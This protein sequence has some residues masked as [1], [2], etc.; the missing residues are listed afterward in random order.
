MRRRAQPA[1][2]KPPP[3]EPV[4]QLSPPQGSGGGDNYDDGDEGEMPDEYERRKPM[5]QRQEEPEA[6]P[7]DEGSA[8]TSQIWLARWWHPLFVLPSPW[9]GSSGLRPAGPK[10]GSAQSSQFSR[11]WLK[12]TAGWVHIHSHA[13]V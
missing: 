11:G 2:R 10:T 9:Y 5:R 12:A 8:Q 6:Q 1:D 13:L 7:E 3:N 4:S